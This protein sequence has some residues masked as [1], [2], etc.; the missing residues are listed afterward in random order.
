M[1]ISGDLLLDFILAR[2]WT[3]LAGHSPGSNT[4]SG[5]LNIHSRRACR[6]EDRNTTTRNNKN[7][8]MC[9][10]KEVPNQERGDS[11]HGEQIGPTD[12]PLYAASGSG[13][14]TQ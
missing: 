12:C 7:D 2:V 6:Y 11:Y 1:G 13:R 5:M 3:T 8:C 10:A 9:W 4:E 14:R